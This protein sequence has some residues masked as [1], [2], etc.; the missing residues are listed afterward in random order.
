MWY[1]Y[2]M[3]DYSAIK[4]EIMPFAATWLDFEIII[5]S[6]GSQRQIP[7]DIASMRNLKH[8]DMNLF[9]Q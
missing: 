4:N 8:G 3:Q 6:E 5:L 9:T 7:Y 2:T 1:T